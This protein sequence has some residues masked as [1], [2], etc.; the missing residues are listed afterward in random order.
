MNRKQRRRHKPRDPYSASK[1]R[2]L[3]HRVNA[4]GRPGRIDG[5]TGACRDCPA[6]GAFILLPGGALIAEV[7]HSEHCPAAAGTVRWSPV[8]A[9]Q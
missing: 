3:Q 1:I 7:F 9:G 2:A 8:P 6:D 4:T 5:L